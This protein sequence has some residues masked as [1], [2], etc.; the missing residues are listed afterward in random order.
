MFEPTHALVQVLHLHSVAERASEFRAILG[1]LEKRQASLSAD[2]FRGIMM[3]LLGDPLQSR[4]AKEVTALLKSHAKVSEMVTSAPSTWVPPGSMVRQPRYR[5]PRRG[6]CYACG[7]LGH[8]ARE[9]FQTKP[10]SH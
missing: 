8:F 5:A 9:C 2:A 6:P 10:Y 3:G 4:I 1:E 7:R